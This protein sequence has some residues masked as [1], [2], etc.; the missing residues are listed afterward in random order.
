MITPTFKIKIPNPEESGLPEKFTAWR[1]NQES[2]IASMLESKNRVTALSAPTGFGKSPAYIAYALLSGKPTCVVTSSRGLQDQLLKD[3]SEIGLVDLRGKNNYPC[4]MRDDFSCHE[5]M[6]ARCPYRES[7]QCPYR[8]AAMRASVSPL[9][10]TNYSKWIADKC[11]NQGLSHIQQVVFD[12]GHDAPEAVAKAMQVTLSADEIEKDLR[13]RYPLSVESFGCWK[14]WA[15]VAYTVAQEEVEIQKEILKAEVTPRSS[16][17]RKYLHLIDLQH[18]LSVLATANQNDW[19]VEE[20]EDGFVFDPIRPV[21]YSESA[22]LLGRPRVIIVSATLRPKTLW[23]LGQGKGTYDFHEFDSEFD[24]RRCPVYYV[25][26]MRVDVKAKDLGMLW[27]R[28]DQIIARRR[29]RKGIIHTI[30]Y[31]RRDDILARS[32]FASSMLVNVKGEPATFTIDVFKKAGPGTILVSPSVG[33]GYDF[34]MKDCE[35]QFMCKIP[36]ADGRAKIVKARQED[37]KEFGPYMAMQTMVQ[38][39]GRGMRSKEDR[40]ENFIA[41]DHLSWFLPKY[42]H[43]APKSFHTFFKQVEYLPQPAELLP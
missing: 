36:F 28:L 18:K 32:R 38:A 7:I 11:D 21:K 16:S 39:F 14:I 29:D 26:T 13:A 31:A 37:D 43:L 19:V 30:S 33:T 27:A 25:P 5:G 17:V 22:L 12:E 6:A 2:A 1:P 15:S 40:C 41:D 20:L 34:P 4:E 9:V 42:R 24:P 10:V 8:Q 3:Y 23:M 35:W